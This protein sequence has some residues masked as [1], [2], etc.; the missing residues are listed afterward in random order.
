MREYLPRT[1]KVLVL[2]TK[3]N[4]TRNK[5]EESKHNPYTCTTLSIQDPPLSTTSG[6]V[7]PPQLWFSPP[8]EVLAG[9]SGYVGSLLHMLSHSRFGIHLSVLIGPLC[10][11]VYRPG[12][13]FHPV[14]LKEQGDV[15][16]LRV[17]LSRHLCQHRPS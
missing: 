8:S 7:F 1:C 14:C 16:H 11:R 15:T 3:Q 12:L 2:K 5:K 6:K 9:P 4:K 17:L 13:C 10:I